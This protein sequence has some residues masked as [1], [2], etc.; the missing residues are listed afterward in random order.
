[1]VIVVARLRFMAV[2][3][4]RNELAI[5]MTVFG[6]GGCKRCQACACASAG[7]APTTEERRRGTTT[8]R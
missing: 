4:G 7:A 8:A 2:F 1:M 3:L 6:L 5:E